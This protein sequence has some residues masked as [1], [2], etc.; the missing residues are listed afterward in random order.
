MFSNFYKSYKYK[1][2]L[3]KAQLKVLKAISSFIDIYSGYLGQISVD[4]PPYVF[5]FYYMYV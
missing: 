2:Q 3:I 4:K 1:I 5:L